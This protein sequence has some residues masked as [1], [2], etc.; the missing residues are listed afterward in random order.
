MGQSKT[1]A[2]CSCKAVGPWR[3]AAAI[4]AGW[5]GPQ[6]RRL[7]SEWMCP[8]CAEQV[9]DL[10]F[11]QAVQRRERERAVLERIDEHEQPFFPDDD[12]ARPVARPVGVSMLGLLLAGLA[13]APPQRGPDR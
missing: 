6:R 3:G 11:R 9:E 8:V 12:C 10:G 1:N 7:R 13:F 2:V 4:K 5:I